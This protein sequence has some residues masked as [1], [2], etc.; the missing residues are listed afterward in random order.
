MLLAPPPNIS[1]HSLMNFTSMSHQSDLSHR[2]SSIEILSRLKESTYRFFSGSKGSVD[3]LGFVICSGKYYFII[4]S[5]FFMF[6]NIVQSEI[7][8]LFIPR[9]TYVERQPK[10]TA[11]DRN[12]RAIRVAA[13]W[14]K[15]HL[16][17]NQD[18]VEMNERVQVVLLTNDRDNA[19]K[20]REDGINTFTSRKLVTKDLTIYSY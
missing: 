3:N 5:Y 6:C 18:D 4:S 1:S 8:Y 9:D 13:K 14:Y 7:L 17:I 2:N 10:E 12:D 15:K 19:E 20:A 11:N 16:E